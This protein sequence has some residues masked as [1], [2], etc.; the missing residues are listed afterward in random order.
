M[1]AMLEELTRWGDNP[2]V[3][4]FVGGRTS[5]DLYDLDALHS[6]A[7]TNPWLQVVSVLEDDPAVVD[8]EHGTL[9]EV[10]TRHGAWADRDVLVAGS[11]AMI[12]ATVSRMLVAGTP[13]DR[14]RYDP[15]TLD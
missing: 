4:I 8:A 11:P 2:Q 5:S 6:M 15:F 10:V 13:L 3:Q 7:A 1:R 14:I 12:R 9:A